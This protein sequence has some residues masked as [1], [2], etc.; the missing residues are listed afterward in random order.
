MTPAEA[1][2]ALERAIALHNDYMNAPS[3]AK[4]PQLHQAIGLYEAALRVYT[5]RDFP[6][7]W[8]TTQNNLATAYGNLPTGDRGANLQRA[9]ACYEA[10]LRGLCT[11][12][13]SCTKKG[14]SAQKV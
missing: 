13:R 12:S 7:D 11:E 1:R 2:A 4:L 8:A 14:D 5:E 3:A 9:I 10:A 6:V